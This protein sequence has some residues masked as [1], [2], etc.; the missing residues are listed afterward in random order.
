MNNHG[1]NTDDD[2]HPLPQKRHDLNVKPATFNLFRF[3]RRTNI[4]IYTRINI[5]VIIMALVRYTNKTMRA[6]INK[7]RVRNNIIIRATNIDP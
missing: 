5:Y 1:Y 7:H 4:Y 2:L 3:R 6:E